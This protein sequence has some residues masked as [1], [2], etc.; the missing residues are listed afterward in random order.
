MKGVAVYGN[1]RQAAYLSQIARF[2][3]LLEERGVAI[4][5]YDEFDNFLRMGGVEGSWHPCRE[6][7][8]EKVRCTTSIGGDGTFLRC[9][10]WCGASG[11]PILGINTGHLG[12]LA[13]Y[14][15][16]ET[17]ELVRVLLDGSGRVEPRMLLKVESPDMP[18]DVWPY[19]L[20]EVAML[21]SDT[22]S[23][24]NI[25]TWIDGNY[26]ADY[27]AD[28]LI[29]ATPTGSTAYNLSVGGPILEPTVENM[30]LSPS[31]PHSLTMRPLVIGG[32]ACVT[33]AVISKAHKCRIS[34]DGRPFTI[35]CRSQVEGCAPE[36]R[37]TKAD[38]SI[39]ILR[40]PD[41]H[42]SQILRNKLLWG[43][44]TVK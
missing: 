8:R 26:L 29:I 2:L 41:S 6:F 5:V 22:A 11:V 21:K 10:Q 3:Q 37:V 14:S 43:Q 31:A 18:S 19:A 39:N 12:F 4:Y 35:R 40:R 44:G 27:L 23:M 25:R 15:F 38:F 28:G 36:L 32:D 1:P 16:D 7:P 42:F 34:I 24:V 20:N 13:S 33:A 9:A 30:V 17:E